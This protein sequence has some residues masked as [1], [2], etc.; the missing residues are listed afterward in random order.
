MQLGSLLEA[1]GAAVLIF[2][3]LG[4]ETGD[5]TDGGYIDGSKSEHCSSLRLRP[6]PGRELLA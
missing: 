2:G 5:I 6:R 1:A 4:I 3:N